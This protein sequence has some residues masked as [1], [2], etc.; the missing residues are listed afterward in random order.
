MDQDEPAVLK[1]SLGAIPRLSAVY[2]GLD[3]RHGVASASTISVAVMGYDDDVNDEGGEATL[4]SLPVEIHSM[5]LYLLDPPDVLVYSRTC[6]AL[7]RHADSQQLWRYQWSKFSRKTPFLFLPA[8]TLVELGANFKDACRRLWQVLVTE[9][10]YGGL[11]PAKCPDCKEYT[12]GSAC[13]KEG[14]ARKVSLD[15]GSKLTWLITSG[16]ELKPHLSMVALPKQLK[17]YDCDTTLDRNAMHCDCIPDPRD[18]SPSLMPSSSS[19]SS[20][21]M[22]DIYCN[23]RL[24]SSHTALNYVSQPLAEVKSNLR[25]S[26]SRPFCLFCEE[27]KVS[28]MRCEREMVSNARLKMQQ[29]CTEEG[30]FMSMSPTDCFETVG[31]AMSAATAV[32]TPMT[33]T[34]G[35]CRD[36]AAILGASNIDVLSPLLALDHVEAFPIVKSFLMHLL[37]QDKMVRLSELYPCTRTSHSAL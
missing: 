11:L 33:L 5:I 1:P 18:H 2:P 37:G 10:V 27:D 7:L 13:I 24:M 23:N 14:R 25:P 31:D 8:N 32:P 26:T 4:L 22:R 35:Y 34:N 28:R 16:Y 9:G 15:I 6:K 29:M 20:S 21:S 19:S 36:T 12:C 30:E 3:R 17:C